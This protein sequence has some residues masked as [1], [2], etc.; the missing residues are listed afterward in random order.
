MIRYCL[1][2]WERNKDILKK[3]F[4]SKDE[5]FI[6]NLSY[7]SICYFT[8]SYILEGDEFKDDIS[9]NLK[10]ITVID[11]GDYQGT[12]LFLIPFD[13]YQP[14]EYEYFMT[15]IGYGSCSVCDALLSLQSQDTKEEMIDDLMLICKDLISNCIVPYNTG[16]RYDEKWEVIKNGNN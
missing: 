16:W 8:F 6:K 3:Y 15:Y 11:N 5:E 14:S 7:K 1:D 12:L 4:L 2:H 9:L 10:E 13:R